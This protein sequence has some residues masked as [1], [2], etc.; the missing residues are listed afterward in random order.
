MVFKVFRSLQEL[1]GVYRC[2]ACILHHR[3]LSAHV[4]EASKTMNENGKAPSLVSLNAFETLGIKP[5]TIDQLIIQ[6]ISNPSDENSGEAAVQRHMQKL[7]RSLMMQYHPDRQHSTAANAVSDTSD[8]AA[9]ITAAYNTLRYIHTRHSHRL[10]LIGRSID[11]N[12]TGSLVGDD[13]LMEIMEIRGDIDDAAAAASAAAAKTDSSS[14]RLQQMLV[15]NRERILKLNIQI[16]HAWR[17]D[18]PDI[19]YAL[20]LTAMLQYYGRIEEAL[21]EY[22]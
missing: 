21:H 9:V 1:Y 16:T 11:E 7:Y 14:D 15:A 3:T 20:K 10:E 19:D 17:M 2:R 18:P 6:S 5:S 8:H 13:F 22:L 12:T 4:N